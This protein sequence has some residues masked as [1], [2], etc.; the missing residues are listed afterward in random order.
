M[1]AAIAGR[2]H[3]SMPSKQTVCSKWCIVELCGVEQL[4]LQGCPRNVAYD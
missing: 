4:K 1:R 2:K 3:G